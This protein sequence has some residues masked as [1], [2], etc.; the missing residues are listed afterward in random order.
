MVK[1]QVKFIRIRTTV[2]LALRISDLP[3]SL[4]IV[5][6]KGTALVYRI[7]CS[8]RCPICHCRRFH[9]STSHHR[10]Y[11][12][13]N[14]CWTALYVSFHRRRRT[15]GRSKRIVRSA[16]KSAAEALSRSSVC[17]SFIVNVLRPGLNTI[18]LAHYVRSQLVNCFTNRPDIFIILL[19]RV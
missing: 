5:Y 16:W 3:I 9:L 19:I 2:W 11:T 10:P 6:K 4:C 14:M 17:I 15:T 1:V 13:P 8:Q 7:T 12:H 18:C